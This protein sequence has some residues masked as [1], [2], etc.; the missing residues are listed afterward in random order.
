MDLK[1]FSRLDS[2]DA[3]NLDHKAGKLND[4]SQSEADITQ[5]VLKNNERARMRPVPLRSM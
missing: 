1:Y 4:L 2:P 5:H 3:S